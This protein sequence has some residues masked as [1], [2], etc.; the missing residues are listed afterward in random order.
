MPIINKKLIDGQDSTTLDNKVFYQFLENE[1]RSE[2]LSSKSL[3][4]NIETFLKEKQIED[5]KVSLK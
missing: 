4:H 2:K 3:I 5:N 1:L